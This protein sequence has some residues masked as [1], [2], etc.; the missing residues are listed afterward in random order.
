[1]VSY[2][3]GALVFKGFEAPIRIFCIAST[4]NFKACMNKCIAYLSFLQI[5]LM[6]IVS[7]IIIVII[8]KMQAHLMTFQYQLSP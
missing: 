4:L 5:M 3:I 1:M 8:S 2:V 6:H 7:T